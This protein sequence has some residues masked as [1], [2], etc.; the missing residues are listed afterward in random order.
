M[1]RAA[2]RAGQHQGD[3]EADE[4]ARQARERVSASAER[5]AHDEHG[6]RPEKP[7]EPGRGHLQGRQGT[8]VE[9]AQQGEGRVV[10]AELPLPHGQEHVD[11]VRVAVVQGV[12]DARDH[13]RAPPIPSGSA[14][15]GTD[16]SGA[17]DMWVFLSRGR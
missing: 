7:G 17:S 13:E 1:L 16:S 4:A 8:G 5:R 2:P 10:Q 11:Q 3:A 15:E 12:V 9:R 6:P 14:V